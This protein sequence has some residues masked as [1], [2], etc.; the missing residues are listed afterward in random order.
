MQKNCLEPKIIT[1]DKLYLAGVVVYG[2]SDKGLFGHAWDILMKVNTGINWKN[3]KIA[4]GVEF[5]TEELYRENKW[6]YMVA[7]EVADLSNIPT[8]MVGK[9]IPA[10]TY[11]VFT[12]IGKIENTKKTSKYG[13]EEWLPKSRYEQADWFEFERYDQRFKGPAEEDSEVD[14]YIPI[15]EK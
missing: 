5:F 7:M 10:N 4:Y 9:V 12:S 11:A 2:N 1:L 13:H 8:N 15:R 3:D 14:I 6:F